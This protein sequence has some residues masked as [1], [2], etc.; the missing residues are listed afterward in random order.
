MTNIPIQTGKILQDKLPAFHIRVLQTKMV[1]PMSELSI[2]SVRNQKWNE[3]SSAVH[4]MPTKIKRFIFNETLKYNW[5][6]YVTPYTI[7]YMYS[8]QIS[9][10]NEDT[11]FSSL[12]RVVLIPL[13][14]VSRFDSEF[15]VTARLVKENGRQAEKKVRLNRISIFSSTK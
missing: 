11:L 5:I 10:F 8:C 4:D 9:C 2:K 1:K 15:C 14:R 3:P 6:Y 13:L 12:L 7:Y